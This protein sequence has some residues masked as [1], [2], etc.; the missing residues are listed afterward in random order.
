[1]KNP[2]NLLHALWAVVT[3]VLFYLVLSRPAPKGPELI[4]A[5][6]ASAS[7]P[8]IYYVNFDSLTVKASYIKELRETSEARQ[9][10][11]SRELERSGQS[12]QNEAREYQQKAATLSAIQRQLTEQ[13]LTRKQQELM[14]RR[15]QITEQLS[16]EEAQ[17]A[18]KVF[19]TIKEYL[20]KQQGLGQV[21]YVLAYQRGSN[22]LLA[23]DS[24]DITQRVLAG[25]NEQHAAEKAQK[26]GK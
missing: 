3:A 2:L 20:R 5:A 8:G 4:S 1:M 9:R 22:I 14:A 15:D 24:L 16:Q 17:R 23:N 7:L 18:E 11:L 13:D 12:L 21:A 19:Q 6:S 10:S 26:K 25:L